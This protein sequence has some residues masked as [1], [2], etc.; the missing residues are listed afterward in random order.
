MVVVC[1]WLMTLLSVA[2]RSPR[3]VWVL[4]GVGRRRQRDVES[5]AGRRRH[6]SLRRR[7]VLSSLRRGRRHRLGGVIVVDGHAFAGVWSTVAGGV[8]D[9]HRDSA[10]ATPGRRVGGA[11]S[12]AGAGTRRPRARDA[13]R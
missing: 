10:G 5:G 6:G 3:V 7:A 9:A 13:R 2:A 1:C 11:F 12:R 4:G 8:A